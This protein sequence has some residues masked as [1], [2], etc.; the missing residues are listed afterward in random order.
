MRSYNPNQYDLFSWVSHR[1]AVVIEPAPA[2]VIDLTPAIIKHICAQPY[3]FPK[4][5]GNVVTFLARR[6][7]A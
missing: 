3:P 4:K 2:E 1:T 7:A 5:D 6:V